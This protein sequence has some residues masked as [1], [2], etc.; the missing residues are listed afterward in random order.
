MYKWLHQLLL[1]SFEDDLLSRAASLSYF[2]VLSTPSL[3]VLLVLFAKSFGIED[4]IANLHTIELMIGGSTN[5]K[6]HLLFAN[7][8]NDPELTVAGTWFGLPLLIFTVSASFAELQSSMNRIFARSPDA[9]QRSNRHFI[10]HILLRRFLSYCMVLLAIATILV[11]LALSTIIKSENYFL[12]TYLIPGAIFTL[13]FGFLY[14]ILP[15]RDL[16]ILQ[17]LKS[18]GITTTLLLLGRALIGWLLSQH[19]VNTPLDVAGPILVTLIWLYYSFVSVL[20]G[21]EVSSI[22]LHNKE[23]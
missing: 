6:L 20:I 18:A 1:K 16:T 4:L 8:L 2:T 11:V 10:Y 3:I 21:A 17:S 12:I 23:S 9:I 13:V 14:Y 5:I 15:E 22:Y 7:V 19:T